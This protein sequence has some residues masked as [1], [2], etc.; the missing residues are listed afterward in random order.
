MY[1]STTAQGVGRSEDAMS[2]GCQD[3]SSLNANEGLQGVLHGGV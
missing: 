1:K 2:A 3:S